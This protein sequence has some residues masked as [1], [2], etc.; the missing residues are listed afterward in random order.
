MYALIMNIRRTLLVSAPVLS[1][2][3]AIACSGALEDT[4]ISPDPG[5]FDGEAGVDAGAPGSGNNGNGDGD[6][7]NG[8]GDGDGDNGNG[9]GDNGNGNG[10]GDNG[11]GNG[12]NGNGDNGNGNGEDEDEDGPPSEGGIVLV[13]GNPTCEDL[14]YSLALKVDPAESGEYDAGGDTIELF[15]DGYYFDWVSGFGIAAVIGKASP[16]AVYWPYDPD[17]FEDEDMHGPTRPASHPQAGEP[18]A[19]G[20]VLFCE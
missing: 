16:A 12:D 8:D 20:H 14:G 19:I 6:N 13:D 1:A 17:A 18:Y 10:N 9:N 15:T 3:F 2:L 5:G 7:G 11:D 4:G